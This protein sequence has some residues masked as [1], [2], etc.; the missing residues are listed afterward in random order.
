M[1]H[2]LAVILARN[3]Q[4]KLLRALVRIPAFREAHQWPALLH[5]DPALAWLREIIT[6]VASEVDR[7]AA[8]DAGIAK[9]KLVRGVRRYVGWFSGNG[10][11]PNGKVSV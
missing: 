9:Q 11:Q 8:G 7:T 3:F 2:R 5:M 4:L 6:D 10:R 1:H